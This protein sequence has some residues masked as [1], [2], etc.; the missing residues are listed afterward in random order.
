MHQ[1]LEN[2]ASGDVV[3]VQHVSLGENLLIPSREIILLA[4]CDTD[5]LGAVN[6]LLL[7]LLHSGLVGN[8][9]RNSLPEQLSIRNGP[10][11]AFLRI[12]KGE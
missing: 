5:K 9:L 2:V 8:S 11:H 1:Y 4:D 7:G 6:G 3:V 10:Q 12:L